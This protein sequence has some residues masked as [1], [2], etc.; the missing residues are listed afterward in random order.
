MLMQLWRPLLE[1][2]WDFSREMNL[3]FEL[4]RPLLEP[5][6]DFSREMNLKFDCFVINNGF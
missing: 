3:K 2:L 4:W 5:L 6:W 1:L